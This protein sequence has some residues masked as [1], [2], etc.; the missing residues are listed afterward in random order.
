MQKPF[1]NA[2]GKGSWLSSRI[3]TLLV[4]LLVASSFLLVSAVFARILDEEQ[5]LQFQIVN[6]YVGFAVAIGTLSIGY[7]IITKIHEGMPANE[8]LANSILLTVFSLVTLVVP[9]LA[10]AMPSV[11]FLLASIAYVFG[12][13]LFYIVISRYRSADQN[14]AANVFTIIGKLLPLFIAVFSISA[15]RLSSAYFFSICG[16]AMTFLM[17]GLLLR[18]DRAALHFASSSRNAF[19]C[20]FQHTASRALDNVNRVAFPTVLIWVVEHTQSTLMAGKIA[21]LAVVLKASES[22]LQQLMLH[23]H[24][25]A[26]QR[27]DNI[28]RRLIAQLFGL[29]VLFNIAISAIILAYGKFFLCLWLS[30][31]YGSLSGE[32]FLM[33]LALGPIIAVPLIRA[34]VDHLF[35]ISPILILDFLLYASLAVLFFLQFDLW[36]LCIYLVFLYWVRLLLFFL[37]V[38]VHRSKKFS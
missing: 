9:V 13:N 1:V 16:F 21:I 34:E 3:A 12:N 8:V 29:S 20:L 37:I 38:S 28:N 35:R 15:L 19:R 32:L 2:S 25:V 6:R 26:I 7:T 30:E 22:I 33:S 31:K 11:E 27:N 5:F 4:T 17:V 24:A 23:S 14:I 10:F 36:N 18:Y